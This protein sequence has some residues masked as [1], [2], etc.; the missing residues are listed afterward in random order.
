MAKKKIRQ[1]HSPLKPQVLNPNVTSRV[2]ASRER[3][4]FSYS[5]GHALIWIDELRQWRGGCRGNRA[6]RPFSECHSSIIGCDSMTTG[7]VREYER[8]RT[9]DEERRRWT[10]NAGWSGRFGRDL[11]RSQWPWRCW[12]TN[13]SKRHGKGVNGGKE[14]CVNMKWRVL[15]F[16]ALL[17]NAP[18]SVYRW[19]V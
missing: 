4:P 18:W 10:M 3:A 2:G 14:I 12:R 19:C 17:A 5:L 1:L 6:G 15:F 13:L 8:F 11:R 7:L 16:F 9:K